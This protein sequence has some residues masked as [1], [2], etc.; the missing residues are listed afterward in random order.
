MLE[1]ETG[2]IQSMKQLLMVSYTIVCVYC[3][4]CIVQLQYFVKLEIARF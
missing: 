3:K 4:I 2:V 1:M